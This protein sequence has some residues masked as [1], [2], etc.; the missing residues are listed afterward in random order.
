MPIKFVERART[1]V[2]AAATVAGLLLSAAMP[3]AAV[4]I[5]YVANLSALNGSGVS[6]TY[7]FSL[8]GTMLTV[9]AQASGLE[10]DMPHL[11][12]IHGLIGADA[13]LTS[14]PT[15]AQDTDG[16]GFIEL[17]EGLVTYGPIILSLTSPPGGAIADFPTAPGGSFTFSQTYDLTDSSIFEGGFGINDL[18]PLENREIVLHGMSVAP[19]VGAGTPGEVDG[20]GGYLLVLPVAAGQIEL[21]AVPEPMSL[22]LLAVGAAGLGVI[23]RRRAG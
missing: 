13:P 22:A 1:P 18:L 10:P 21:A 9:T 20:T 16:D 15:L 19:G 8:D 4:P 3:A 17:L 23:R 6:A 5:E 11:Q 7:N 12:H 2:I 14:T